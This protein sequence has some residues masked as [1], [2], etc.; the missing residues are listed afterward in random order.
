MSELT[1]L[2]QEVVLDHGRR[3]R[4]FGPLE[5]ATARFAGGLC[6]PA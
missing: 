4:N 5:G 2:Y 3:P 1:D 6:V